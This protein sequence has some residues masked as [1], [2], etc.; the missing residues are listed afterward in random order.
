LLGIL[1]HQALLQNGGLVV[2]LEMGEEIQLGVHRI[3]AD[4]AGVRGSHV[5]D[6]LVLV[7]VL[8]VGV[9]V[10]LE[11][12]RNAFLVGQDLAGVRIAGC[13][14]V[15]IKKVLV[16]VKTGGHVDGNGGLYGQGRKSGLGILL[17]VVGHNIVF[18]RRLVHKLKDGI[19]EV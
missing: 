2:L 11:L 15:G 9:Y 1:N 4:F 5:L 10:A 14:V 6:V 12:P 7:V 3:A 19:V 16:L 8:Q 13:V 17:V 18:R